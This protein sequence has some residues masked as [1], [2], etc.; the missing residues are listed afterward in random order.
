MTNPNRRAAGA[1][2]HAQGHGF[3]RSLDSLHGFY[4]SAGRAWVV[5]VPAPS[6][7]L[8][9]LGKGR[10]TGAFEGEGPPDYF[11]VIC[12]RAVVFDAKQTAAD[13]WGFSALAEHQAEHF[14][15]VTLQGGFAF[16]LL[17]LGGVVR[18]V[19]WSALGPRWWTWCAQTG[20]A[21]PGTASLSVADLDA[22]GHRCQGCDW[23]PVV[24]RLLG[25]L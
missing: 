21:V 8:K 17:W 3:E 25:A 20:R 2:G 12:G 19:P 7:V 1:R 6:R 23:L 14:E 18:V 5:K 11:A 9:M 13:R 16:V 24:V 15:E 4:R 10:F 22:I